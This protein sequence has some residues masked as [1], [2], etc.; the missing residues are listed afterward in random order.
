MRLRSTSIPIVDLTNGYGNGAIDPTPRDWYSWS[1]NAALT[2]LAGRHTLKFGGD[3]RTIGIKTQSFSGGAGDFHFD[4]YFTS[5]NPPS[6][7]TTG[8]PHRQRAG[9]TAAGVSHG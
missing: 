9:V 6:N 2:R 4:R 3:F 5:S 8:R 1:A 7:G